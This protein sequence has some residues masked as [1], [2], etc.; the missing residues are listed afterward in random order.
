MQKQNVLEETLKLAWHQHATFEQHRVFWQEL[1]ALYIEPHRHYHNLQHLAHML[2]KLEEAVQAMGKPD[3]QERAALL[4]ALLYHDAVY[5]P[6][7]SDNEERSALLFE[8]HAKQTNYPHVQRVKGLILMTKTHQPGTDKLSQLFSDIDLA[9]LGEDTAA[10]QL[11][12]ER[13]RQEYKHVP[14][15]LYRR[16]RQKVLKQLLANGNIFYTPY[17]ITS[18]REKAVANIQQELERL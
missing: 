18:Y 11:Y 9:I 8:Q 6:N 5:N 15:F 12:T 3:Q 2:Q 10:Y 7:K 16:G 1:Q 14:G 13:I 4:L 17:F